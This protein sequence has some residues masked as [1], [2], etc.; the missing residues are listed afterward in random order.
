MNEYIDLAIA[1]A[2]IATINNNPAS[3]TVH[4]LSAAYI[5]GQMARYRVLFLN[6]H[7]ALQADRDRATIAISEQYRREMVK[8]LA[9]SCI[10]FFSLFLIGISSMQKFSD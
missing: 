4:G 1:G 9:F 2:K 8:H 10:D 7:S 5:I 6:G 3:I